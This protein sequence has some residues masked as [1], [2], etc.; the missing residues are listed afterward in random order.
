[1]LWTAEPYEQRQSVVEIGSLARQSATGAGGRATG[2]PD[3]IIPTEHNILVAASC[4]RMMEIIYVLSEYKA[5]LLF[6]FCCVPPLFLLLT[7]S[8]YKGEFKGGKPTKIR[9]VS[10][11][12]RFVIDRWAERKP[13]ATELVSKLSADVFCFQ[14]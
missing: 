14:V 6:L 11:N 9:V 7:K 8:E 13:M 2:A 1:M 10:F 3:I 4:S 12:L 5:L